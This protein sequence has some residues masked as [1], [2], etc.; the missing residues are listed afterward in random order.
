MPGEIRPLAT[1]RSKNEVNFSGTTANHPAPPCRRAVHG[2]Q[3]TVRLC[4]G[5]RQHSGSLASFGIAGIIPDGRQHSGWRAALRMA[6][7]TPDGGQHSGWRAALRMAGSTPD[8]GQHSRSGAVLLMAGSTLD[9][10]QQSYQCIRPQCS[11]DGVTGRSGHPFDDLT[12]RSGILEAVKVGYLA[13][14]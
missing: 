11:S 9:G 13:W 6:G 2:R 8:G 7:S 12:S 3:L 4:T 1:A 10:G 5:H 14:A